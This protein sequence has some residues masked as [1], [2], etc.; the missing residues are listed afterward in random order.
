MTQDEADRLSAVVREA[1]AHSV[2]VTADG[3][4]FIVT[5]RRESRDGTETYT[6][7]DEADWSWLRD[8]IVVP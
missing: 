6:L 8:R 3:D 7:Y 4:Y 1:C 5:V 2:G